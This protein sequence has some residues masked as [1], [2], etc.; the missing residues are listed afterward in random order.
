MLLWLSN[1]KLNYRLLNE[2]AGKEEILATIKQHKEA[3][4]KFLQANNI[5]QPTLVKDG[6]IFRSTETEHPLSYAQRRLWFL[7]EYEGGSDAYNIPLLFQLKPETNHHLLEQS[8]H[9][10]IERHE[11]L[12]SVIQA[13]EAGEGYQVLIDSQ[14]HPF[15]VIYQSIDSKEALHKALEAD[16]RHVFHLDRDYPIRVVLYEDERNQDRYISIVVHHVA[17]DGWSINVFLKELQTAYQ[18]LQAGNSVSEALPALSIQYKDFALW[19]KAYLTGERL[20][21]QLAYWEKQLS[22]YET[23][24]LPLDKPRP[25]QIDYVGESIHF[26][27][28]EQVSNHLRDLAK[29]LNVSL[30]S[31]LLSGYYLLLSSYSNQK[32]IVLG[33]P[34]ANRHYSQLEEL[35]G[36]FVNNLVLRAQVESDQSVVNFIASVGRSVIEAQ[37][38][39]DLPFERLVD[40]LEVEKDTSRHPIFQVMF[41]VQSFDDTKDNAILNSYSNSF[42]YEIAKFDLMTMVDNSQKNLKGAFNYATSLFKR[43]TIEGYIKTYEA[44]LLQLSKLTT[45]SQTRIADLHYLTQTDAEVMLETWNDTSVPYSDEKTVFE[46]FEAQVARTPDAIAL[47]YE[48]VALTYQALNARANQVAHYLQSHYEL[49]GDD[50]VGLCLDRSEHMLIAILGVLKAGGAYV[51][52]DPSYPD[53]RMAYIAQDTQAKVILTNASYAER[54]SKVITEA[55]LDTAILAIDENSTQ[56][57]LSQLPTENLRRTITSAN[58][59]YVIYTSGT[60]GQPK[61]VMLAHQGV[62]NRIEWMNAR[63]PL[64]AG[65]RILQKTPYVFDVS[66]WE[67]FWANWYGAT[68]VFAKPEGHKEA[69]Y[70]MET[71]E[72]YQISVIHFVPSMLDMFLQVLEAEQ[73]VCLE[74]LRSLRYIFCSGEALLASSVR[75]CLRLIPTA[76][77]HNLYGPTEASIDVLSYDCNDRGIEQVYIGKPIANTTAYVLNEQLQPVPMGAIGELYIGGDGLAR[78]YL[79]RAALTQERFIANPYQRESERLAGRNARLYKTGDLVRWSGNGELEYLGRNDFQVKIRGFRIELGE[80]EAALA[81]HPEIQQ[82]VVIAKE[83]DSGAYLVGYYVAERELNQEALSSY[84]EARLPAY[85]V[86]SAFVH[87]SQLPLTVNGKVDRQALPDPELQSQGTY[88]APRNMLEEAVCG[89][90]AEVLGL[91]VE[92]V[93]IQDDFF[94]LGGDSIVSIQLVSRFRQRLK[95]QVS[96]KDIFNYKTVERLCDHVLSQEDSTTDATNYSAK[97]AL[98]VKA[99]DRLTT[100]DI[101]HI[102]SQGYLD[103]LQAEREVSGVYLA[104]NLQQG[105]IYHALNQ[106]EQ[107]DAYRVQVLFDYPHAL[108]PASL[109]E[110]WRYAQAKYASLRLRLD[111]E[112]ALIQIIDR[113]GELHWEA[114]DISHEPE[115]L[116]A[117]SIE[118][119]IAADRAKPYDL[120]AGSL[121]RICLIKQ[122]ETQYS[123][124]VSSHHAILD[125][126][127]HGVLLGYVHQTYEAIE[128]GQAEPIASVEVEHSYEAA[129]AY[130]QSH[131]ADHEAFWQDYLSQAKERVDLSGLLKPSQRH[132][133]L[134][135]YKYLSTPAE[136]RLEITD[137]LY[138]SLKAFGQAHG[139]TMNALLQ[140]AWHKVL[141]AYGNAS[142]TVVGMTVSGRHLPVDGVEQSVGLYINTLPLIVQHEGEET[143]LAT[144]QKIQESVGDINSHSNVSL[145]K[146]QA[147]GERLFDSLLVYE[148]YPVK[149]ANPEALLQPRFRQAVEKLDYPLGVMAYE[150]ERGLRVNLKYAGELFAT[151]TMATVLAM[152]RQILSQVVANPNGL[153]KAIEWLTPGQTTQLLE[154]WNATEAAYPREQTLVDLFEAQVART[155]DAIALYCETTELTYAELNARANQV[156]HYLREHYQL[157]GDD[158]VGLCLDRSEHMLIAI[159]GVLKAGAAYVPID[160]NYPKTRIDYIV[161]EINAK[162][163]FTSTAY[164][165]QLTQT[166]KAHELKTTLA[167]MDASEFK[168]ILFKEPKENLKSSLRS[169]HL[170]YVIY[171]SGTTGQP[172][173]V[174]I[175]HA[176]LSGF[177]QNFAKQPYIQSLQALPTFKLLSTTQYVFDIFGLEYGL[178]LIL[179]GAIHLADLES[180]VQTKP[181]DI[182]QY[183]VIQLTPL[184]LAVLLDHVK[185]EGLI[186]STEPK[187]VTFLI[188]GEALTAHVAEK[189]LALEAQL[190]QVKIKLINVYG[191]AETTIWSTAMEIN[192]QPIKIGRPLLNETVYVLDQAL[193]ALPVGA[194]GELYIGGDG[195]A[196]GYL[197]LAALTQERFITNPYQRESERL[198]GRNARL[199]KTGDLVRWSGNGELEYLGRNDFQV[200]I[201]GFRIELGE[202]EAALAS[203]PEIQQSVVLAKERDSGAYLVG[204]YVASQALEPE[205][206][207][208]YLEVRLPAYMIPSAFVHLSQ[209]PLTVNGK[210]DRQALPDPEL[211][212]QATY[213]A[214]RNALEEDVCALYADVLGLSVEQV[215]IQDDFFRLGGDS[216]VSIQLTSRLRRQLNVPV[217]VKDIFQYKTVK[218]L[219]EQVLS[220]Q[221]EAVPSDTLL[222]EQGVLTGTLGLL[223]VQQWFFASQH[224]KPNHWNQAFLVD[225]PALEIERLTHS[226]AKL[227]DYHDAFRLRYTPKGEQYYAEEGTAIELKQL[228]LDDVPEAVQAKKLAEIL[229]AWQSDF[230]ITAGPLWCIGYISGYPQGRARLYFAFHHL[231]VDTVS[232]RILVDDLEK[233]YSA[234]QAASAEAVLGAKGTSYRQWVEVVVDYGR[235]HAS[236]RAYWTQVMSDYSPERLEVLVSPDAKVNYG[237]M[238][239]DAK[240]TKQLS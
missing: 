86:P 73:E 85:M 27:L 105:F 10:V 63:Y 199:Y 205:A 237:Q 123:C 20:D 47:M 19:Q 115:A 94:R 195:L 174:M 121:F 225:V 156:A 125:G 4:I 219:C 211:Q 183:D 118:G 221:V 39:Q 177:L 1:G 12:R 204:Y 228:S 15:A 66:V 29:Q 77:I 31:V 240:V 229:T 148:N 138:Q 30:Y 3:I 17:F 201:R 42:N 131:Q 49:V 184:K 220:Q 217:S 60:T 111:W 130:L 200:K 38:Y 6:D 175:E 191:P 223:P 142:V 190:P 239:L 231:I 124:L 74:Q 37:L 99:G 163:I 69:T 103:K 178:P 227:V 186:K 213:V 189:L 64:T 179:G 55:K 26:S 137:G 78:G 24:H 45:E 2:I 136:A 116:Q 165:E 46:L 168:E 98:R 126:W 203:H 43:E 157:V 50:L 59:A 132:V 91:P 83:R 216:I 79:N 48:D 22:G 173:G 192:A 171:T 100:E 122:S 114:V 75:Q 164:E 56:A 112:E 8:L 206:L 198:A 71:I 236:E 41:G 36:F 23:L 230:D 155:P 88:V 51:P 133:R 57:E 181:V 62:V 72:R 151:E 212:S 214:P 87:L 117:K 80:I 187:T 93:G 108:N 65:D 110:A 159:L 208:S 84:L 143:V 58:L 226:L 11:V 145:A 82:S 67:L 218:Q 238:S 119:L 35:I 34:V 194:I 224:A 40:L 9:C 146:L 147:Q 160:P 139:I 95:R 210:V 166:L 18:A 128:R 102:I 161:N 54:L 154:E 97:Q 44:I 150:H 232:W 207:I 96:I 167:S 134:S 106:G 25:A 149:A 7:E 152:L 135:E 92:H 61:G 76:E 104:N 193:R 197:N 141:S 33:T 14:A 234:P 109:K 53:A 113:A 21:E 235:R 70:L 233:L 90:Y 188:G 202:I 215:G 162:I 176:Q 129:Q 222:E 52:L 89:L 101:D 153:G 28:D 120:R 182:T 169:E 16:T 180:L 32:D 185:T 81:S 144:L 5:T 170:A 140:Y 209:L 196:R 13:N 158:L 107:D 127:S 68:I 172:K